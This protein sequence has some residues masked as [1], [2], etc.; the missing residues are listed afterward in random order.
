MLRARRRGHRRRPRARMPTPIGVSIGPIVRHWDR[1][2]PDLLAPF[3]IPLWPPRAIRLARLRAARDP[4]GDIARRRFRGERARALLAGAAAHSQIGL[5]EPVSGA[6]ALVMLA[7]AHADGWPS[8]EG[9]ASR[10]AEAMAAEIRALGGSIETGRPVE[11]LDDLPAHRVA[12]F[13]V[14]PR[15]LL[16]IAGDAL[17]GGLPRR[18]SRGSATG[19]ASSSSTWRST[20]RSPGARPSSSRAGTVHVGGTL[21][22]IVRSEAVGRARSASRSA[23]SCCSRSR[24][25]SIASRAPAGRETVWAYCHVPNGSTADMTEPI[26]GQIERFAPGFRERILATVAHGPAQL[27]AYNANDVGGDIAGGRMDLGQLFTRP[28]LRLFDP[29]ATPDPRS[30]SARRRRRRAAASTGC[31][32][33]TPRDRP[34]VSFVSGSPAAVSCGPWRTVPRRPVRRL[35]CPGRSGWP[36]SS[37]SS[38]SRC[39]WRGPSSTFNGSTIRATSGWFS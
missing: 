26:L 29:Y 31:P 22:E 37:R 13:D 25:G 39:S 36:W 27:E 18:V 23:R 15:Q 24:A 17:P 20:G 2:L 12:L 33:S 4:I 32:G 30:S 21:E 6:A 5:T 3:H 7:S 35:A 14:T 8:P 1:L 10:L 34:S 9:G 11:R 28:S 19:P 16:A 38:G